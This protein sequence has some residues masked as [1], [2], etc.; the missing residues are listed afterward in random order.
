[1][2]KKVEISISHK[3]CIVESLS[4]KLIALSSVLLPCSFQMSDIIV[5]VLHWYR[6]FTFPHIFSSHFI[7]L[8]VLFQTCT[9]YWLLQ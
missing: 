9:W 3:V 5:A 7:T 4:L 1:M 2:T 8:F 6:L